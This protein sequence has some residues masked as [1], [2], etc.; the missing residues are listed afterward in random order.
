[1]ANV[2][3]AV[4]GI[5]ERGIIANL[6]QLYLHDFS[7]ILGGT[8]RADRVVLGADGRFADYPLD[9]W[10]R[11][12]ECIPLIIRAGGRLAGFALLNTHGHSGLPTDR[13]MAEFFIVRAFRR[14]GTGAAAA[15]AIFSG[16]PGQ[17][18]LSVIRPNIAAMAFWRRAV[19][20]APGVSVITESEKSDAIWDGTILRFCAGTQSGHETTANAR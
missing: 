15:H 18:E 4:A 1:M 9:P 13:N 11:D 3:V 17:W 10:W 16:W 20:S 12:P 7:E 8:N 5:D 14:T 2:Q 19:G 6:I